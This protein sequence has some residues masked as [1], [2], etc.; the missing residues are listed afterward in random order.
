MPAT[1]EEQLGGQHAGVKCTGGE[2]DKARSPGAL[3]VPVR[4]GVSSA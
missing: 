1:L 2:G 4:T 3:Q